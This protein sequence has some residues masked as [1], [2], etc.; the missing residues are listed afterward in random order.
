MPDAALLGL[1]V[2]RIAAHPPPTGAADLVVAAF[3]G[4]TAVD[5]VLRA[6][7][8]A[9]VCQTGAVSFGRSGWQWEDIV[10]KYYPGC[11]IRNI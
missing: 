2:D 1:V 7:V 10:A 9:W 3:D 8:M 5:S 11:V 6:A 4:S